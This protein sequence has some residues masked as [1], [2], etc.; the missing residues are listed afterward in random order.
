MPEIP[1]VQTT[2]NGLNKHVVGLTIKDVWTDYRSIS[3]VGKDNIKDKTFF[4]NF[5]KRL[6]NKKISGAS[7]RAKNVLVHLSDGATILIHMK[8]TGHIMYGKYVFDKKKKK[9][10][11]EAADKK[12]PLA[13]SFNQFIRLVFTLSDKKYLV[14]SDMRRFAKVTL[15]ESG[16]LEESSHL[17]GLGPEPLTKKFTYNIFKES[18]FR[19]PTGRIKNV[20]MDQ[21]LIAGIGNIYSD[22]A[23][24]RA[25]IHPESR[26]EKI[27]EK[28]LKLLYPAILVVLK[29]GLDFGGDS[30]S[31]YRNLEGEKG[32]FQLE[33]LA[34]RRTGKACPKKG[35][36]GKIVRK[37]VGGRSAHF[38]SVHQTLFD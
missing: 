21:E 1:E 35:C 25:N 20:L 33:H 15:I 18:I 24:F 30:A 23:L 11:W 32:R 22:E 34:Y 14:L 29:K 8:M 5:R 10:P 17:K 38:C 31:D 36:R 9:D 28:N 7:R 13:D 16:N 12:S 3:H 26:V 6:L 4:A 37:V 27:P 19:R 2:V